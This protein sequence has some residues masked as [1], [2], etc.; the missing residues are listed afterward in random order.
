MRRDYYVYMAYAMDSSVT[1]CGCEL[2][3]S[4]TRRIHVSPFGLSFAG[5][6]KRDEMWP[7]SRTTIAIPSIPNLTAGRLYFPMYQHP[8][9]SVHPPTI[10]PLMLHRFADD[11]VMSGD[12]PTQAI[13]M[14]DDDTVLPASSVEEQYEASPTRGSESIRRGRASDNQQDRYN[15]LKQEEELAWDRATDIWFSIIDKTEDPDQ[16]WVCSSTRN[17]EEAYTQMHQGYADWKSC[18]MRLNGFIDSKVPP[19]DPV[20][21][22]FKLEDHNVYADT[23]IEYVIESTVLPLSHWEEMRD[24]PLTCDDPVRRRL[25]PAGETARGLIGQSEM[26]VQAIYLDIQDLDDGSNLG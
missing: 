9:A 19:L 15:R 24:G 16:E 18:Y 3:S 7:F 5:Y 6:A 8:D 21:R 26:R 13:T 22:R 2:A 11:T 14:T 4:R 25:T 20:E 17:D 12:K 23:K 10:D 1:N